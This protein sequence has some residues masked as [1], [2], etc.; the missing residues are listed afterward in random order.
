MPH[1]SRHHRLTPHDVRGVRFPPSRFGTRGYRESD[2]DAFLDLLAEALAERDREIAREREE[3]HRI[4]DW[5]RSH[6]V[7]DEG[8]R[9][10]TP[11]EVNIYSRAQLRAESLEARAQHLLR[12]SEAAARQ[13]FDEIVHQASD[14]AKVVSVHASVIRNLLEAQLQRLIQEIH[15][16]GN[17]AGGDAEGWQADQS[18]SLGVHRADGRS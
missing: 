14:Q 3:I 6:G 8:R 18:P 12:Q 10:P 9:E 16:L 5:R 2:V 15:D 17:P 4:R 13:R 11:A 1:S 7:P